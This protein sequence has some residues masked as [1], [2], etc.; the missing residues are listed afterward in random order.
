M[1]LLSRHFVQKGS[2]RFNCLPRP[3]ASDTLAWFERYAWPGNVRELEH[4]VYQGLLLS[5]GP[6]ISIPPP[7]SA[8]LSTVAYQQH[9]SYRLAKQQAMADSST[10][11]WC[12]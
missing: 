5:E 10:P 7:P 6:A 8:A 2:A 12:G 11:I 3:I 4:V 1:D 9:N